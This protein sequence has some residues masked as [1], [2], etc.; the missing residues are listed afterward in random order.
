MLGI[1]PPGSDVCGVTAT[2]IE[3]GFAAQAAGT[4]SASNS[5]NKEVDF[6][7]ISLSPFNF[8][9]ASTPL[10]RAGAGHAQSTLLRKT[11]AFA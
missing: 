3:G 2:L 4:A 7:R 11:Q 6:A 10:L 1:T 9:T 5:N 8:L